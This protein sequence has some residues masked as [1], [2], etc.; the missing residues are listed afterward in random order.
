[1]LWD[2]LSGGVTRGLEQG[3]DDLNDTRVRV[4]LPPVDRLHGGISE[5]LC[6]VA[7]FPQ[8]E[9]AR[10]WPSCVHVVGPLMWEPPSDEVSPPPGGEPLV[11][12]APSTAQ[13]RD[14]RLLRAALSGLADEPIRVLATWNRRPLPAPAPV[15]ANERLVEWLSYARTMPG[16]ALVICNAGHGTLVRA[17][18]S[19]APVLAVPHAGDMNENAARLDWV[20][21]GVRLPWPLL[22]G[23]SIR[24]AVRYA[25]ARRSFADRAAALAAWATA[26]DAAGRAADLV[27]AL[28]RS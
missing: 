24:Y 27:E 13:D 20:G 16:C 1:M 4:G 19:G 8:L 17:L 11:L 10:E 28:A 9:Y 6:I 3:R 25:L 26:H 18:A 15:A 23:A 2:R 7:T 14:H 12:V 21:A 5:R 22:S